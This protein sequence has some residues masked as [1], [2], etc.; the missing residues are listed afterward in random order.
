MQRIALGIV[1]GDDVTETSE[2]VPL[3]SAKLAAMKLNGGLIWGSGSAPPSPAGRV[4]PPIR[5]WIRESLSRLSLSTPPLAPPCSATLYPHQQ[6]SVMGASLSQIAD[7]LHICGSIPFRA[8]SQEGFGENAEY[9]DQASRCGCPSASITIAPE[10]LSVSRDRIIPEITIT[11]TAEWGDR[12]HSYS[13][14]YNGD[15]Y[16]RSMASILHPPS[17]GHNHIGHLPSVAKHL[18]LGQKPSGIAKSRKN[19]TRLTPHNIRAAIGSNTWHPDTGR[20]G[21]VYDIHVG[22][23]CSVALRD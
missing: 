1:P 2:G 3:E 14:R 4:R 21:Q 5:P 23:L 6:E 12:P 17:H 18:P 22:A 19:K 16:P 15:S 10:L 13:T 8:Q 11:D 9:H 20:F 7:S